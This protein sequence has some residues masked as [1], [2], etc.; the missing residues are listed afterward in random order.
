V[1]GSFFMG[2]SERDSKQIVNT[3]D[4]DGIDAPTAAV[5]GNAFNFNSLGKTKFL[6]VCTSSMLGNPPANY[7][8][9]Y[10]HLKAAS[11][12]PTQPLKGLQHC[13]Y[14]NGDETYFDTYMNVPRMVDQLLELA[15][16]RRFYARG[17]AGEPHAPTS[18]AAVSADPWA[19]GMWSAMSSANVD[20]APIAWNAHWEG[21]KPNHHA[22]V[23][24]WDMA[25][26]EGKFGKPASISHFSTPGASL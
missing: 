10:Y 14:G 16:S 7:W 26:L 17:E 20:D 8:E 6:V 23:T 5:E 19:A 22:D 18:N 24:D 25:K 13:V 12:N 1:Y 4:V 21:S 15:G 2:D 3:F 11:Q 9:F